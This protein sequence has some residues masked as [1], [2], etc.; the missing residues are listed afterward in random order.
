MYRLRKTSMACEFP[1]LCS[2]AT[3]MVLASAFVLSAFSSAASVPQ[4]R[5]VPYDKSFGPTFYQVILDYSYPG[6]YERMEAVNFRNLTLYVFDEGKKVQTQGKLGNGSYERKDNFGYESLKLDSVHYLPSEDLNSQFALVLY[7]W[8]SVGG[9]SSTDGVAQIY[10]LKNHQLKLRQQFGWDEHF[11][12]DKK[13][14]VFSEES[15][16]LTVRSAHYMPGDAHCCVSAADV[17]A[18]R[19]DGNGFT[20]RVVS[21][22]LSEFGVKSKK[23]L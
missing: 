8:F 11:G 5:G 21:V 22:E 14:A 18:L 20:K 23:K 2:F 3:A 4:S 16:T 1:S 6:T 19:W 12:T 17:V 10:E 13:Y 15:R 7:T 9:S